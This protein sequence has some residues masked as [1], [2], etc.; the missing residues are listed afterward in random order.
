MSAL[1]LIINVGV[2]VLFCPSI[3]EITHINKCKHTHTHTTILRPSWILSGTTR[4]SQHQK[5]KTRK[6]EPIWIYWSKR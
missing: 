6:A 4:V 1:K 5:G 2:C 3:S